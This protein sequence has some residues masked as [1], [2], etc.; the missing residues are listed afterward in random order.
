MRKFKKLP[1]H[2]VLHHAE[3]RGKLD[4]KTIREWHLARGWDDIGYHFVITGSIFDD[5]TELQKGRALI[6]QGA[7]AYGF[8]GKSIG[9]CMTGHGDHI[10]WPAKQQALLLE[11]LVYLMDQ[12]NIPIQNVIGHR[13]TPWERLKRNKTCPGN[14]IDMNE[15]RKYILQYISENTNGE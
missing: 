6:M 9:I 8:N 7:H 3:F 5:V 10:E 1:T 14:L 2:I 12:F 13:E 4:A 11:T 15:V